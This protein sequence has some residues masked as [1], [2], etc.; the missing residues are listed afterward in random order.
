M[1]DYP[2]RPSGSNATKVVLVILAVAGGLLFVC[3]GGA[4]ALYLM[5]APSLDKLGEGISQGIEQGLSEGL[6]EFDRQV[7]ADVEDHPL[8]VEHIGAIQ[9]FRHDWDASMEE[10]G[11]DV[12][13]F[14]IRGEKGSGR[15]RAECIT[16]DAD[17]EDVTSGQLILD[18][19][20]TIELF[21]A[22]PLQ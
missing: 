11:E 19:G 16:I 3:C 6:D 21:P 14:D 5:V 7:Q 17:T 12:W 4:A 8:I 18:S 20:E 2:E 9:E 1:N 13:V 22:N 10:P 15:L